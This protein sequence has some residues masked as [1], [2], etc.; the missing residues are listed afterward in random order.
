VECL[1]PEEMRVKTEE[2]H[3]IGGHR[4]RDSMKLGLTDR[5]KTPAIGKII[6]AAIQR[7]RS[8]S[9]TS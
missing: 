3:R 6:M 8:S 4:G 5:F 7:I 1:T 9:F 2:E